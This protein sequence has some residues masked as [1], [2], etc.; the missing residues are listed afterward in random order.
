MYGCQQ[1]HHRPDQAGFPAVNVPTYVG[2]VA[3]ITIELQNRHRADNARDSAWAPFLFERFFD[4][5][6]AQTSDAAAKALI[7]ISETR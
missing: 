1:V 3:L 7:R 6:I 2:D 5:A 4:A